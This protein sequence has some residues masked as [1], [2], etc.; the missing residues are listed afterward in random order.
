[1]PLFQKTIRAKSDPV[2]DLG[3]ALDSA[4]ARAL[5]ANVPVRTVI[6][7]L[8]QQE[9]NARHRMVAAFRP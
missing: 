9:A 2:A 8:E 1:M 7:K 3:E 6:E 4:V 5:A